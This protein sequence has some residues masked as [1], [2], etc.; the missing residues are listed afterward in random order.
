VVHGTVLAALGTAALVCVLH[1][2]LASPV[3]PRLAGVDTGADPRSVGL[4]LAVVAVLGFVLGPLQNA[5]SRRIENRA[6]TYAL[7]L[8]R[9]PAVFAAMQ[10]RLA[11]TNLADLDPGRVP[12]LL[13]ASHPTTV[14]RIAAAQAFAAGAGLPPVSGD[15]ADGPADGPHQVREGSA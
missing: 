15:T 13:F 9:E 4:L 3:A 10:R 14:Q 8:S 2:V 12:Y 6:D 5:V 7:R 1:L 11:L